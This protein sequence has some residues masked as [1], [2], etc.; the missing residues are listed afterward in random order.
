MVLNWIKR[1]LGIVIT[2]SNENDGDK[3]ALPK[4]LDKEHSLQELDNRKRIVQEGKEKIKL[5][6]INW[7]KIFIPKRVE[8]K[9]NNIFQAYKFSKVS[10]LKELKEER[11]KRE[12]HELKVLEDSVKV[13]LIDIESLIK[14]RKAED[15]KRK[16]STALE[17]IVK[18]KDSSIRQRLLHLQICLD[19]LFTELKQEE[20]VR[21][22]EER[23]RREEEAQRK[24]EA[25]ERVKKEKERKEREERERRKAE[26]KRFAI[27]GSSVRLM[28][29]VRSRDSAS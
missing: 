27:A 1:I 23:R 5:S 13:L 18:I 26:A 20:L 24:K 16:L 17:K 3:I 21:L 4:P 11:L 19:K 25:E 14:K 8:K 9:P 7:Y 6:S 29:E 22:A 15:A 28:S 12:A 10:T 2:P